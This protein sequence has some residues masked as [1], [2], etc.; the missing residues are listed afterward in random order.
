MSGKRAT[1]SDI[2][3]AAGVSKTTVSRYINGQRDRISPTTCRRIEIAVKTAH[4]RPSAAARTLKS[5]R[6]LL[7]A[8][9]IRDFT[10]P[11]TARFA[12]EASTE[13]I[14]RGLLPITFGPCDTDEAVRAQA[15]V[16]GGVQ[17]GGIVLDAAIG[18]QAQHLIVGDLDCPALVRTDE[19]GAQAAQRL[20]DLMQ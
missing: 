9:I 19:T 17:P 3:M 7:V 2:A 10:D 12:Q 4:Y 20:A 15:S 5:K 16:L 13:L 8:I 18:E 14:Q 11:S 6:S 1:I